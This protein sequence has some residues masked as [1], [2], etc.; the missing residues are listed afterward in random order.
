VDPDVAVLK[1]RPDIASVVQGF[2]ADE[3]FAHRLVS[4]ATMGE[5]VERSPKPLASA[6]LDALREPIKPLLHALAIPDKSS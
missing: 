2:C 6:A 5:V 4:A 1:A 3:R